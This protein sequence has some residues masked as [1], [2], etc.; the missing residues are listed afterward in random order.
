[1]LKSLA[2]L[3]DRP[4]F[5][6]VA[7]I[8]VPIA[9]QQLISAGLNM[10]D[11]V[12]VGQLGD[13]AI[14][15]LGLA[16][17]LFFLLALFLFGLTSGMAIFTAQF[18][19]KRDLHSIRQVLGICLVVA[20]AMAVPFTVVAIFFPAQVLGIY[21]Q[22]PEVIRLG[23]QYLR[24]V[25]FTYILFAVTA[26]YN[27]V[28]RSIHRVMLATGVM[29][30]ALV[31]KSVLGYLLIFGKLG[32][33][34]LG[35]TGA[36]VATSVARTVECTLL[37][38]L[39]YFKRGP[40]AA[41]LRELFTINWDLFKKVLKTAW[42]ATVNE[43]FWSLGITAYNYVYA[44]IGTGAIAAVNIN[45]AVDQI[46]WVIFIGMANAGAV[47]VGNR[48]GAGEPETAHEYGRR[49]LI[50]TMSSTLVTG[51]LVILLRDPILSLYHVSAGSAGFARTL[52]LL[53][54]LTSW[55]RV[56]NLIVFIGILRAGGDTKYALTVEALAMWLVGV[57]AAF[58]GGLVFKLPLPVVYLL[59]LSEEVI[60]SVFVLRRFLS[61]KYIHNLVAA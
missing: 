52:M 46:V 48:I 9:L 54:A 23:S 7:T 10:F 42:P 21:T 13:A 39:I 51:T 44:H 8:A 15:A 60:K 61:R 6:E 38:S 59:I 49:L 5:K 14:A 30:F 19:G 40:L 25:G 41:P 28:L 18:W 16:N 29:M 27:V 1:M 57:P 31:F 47:M 55:L 20:L 24:S 50:L 34:A 12:L 36:G 58:L 3:R 33:P 4:F 43:I 45:G 35:V 37:I 56:H 22:D 11:V 2:F 53:S 26:S 17:Q 32:F